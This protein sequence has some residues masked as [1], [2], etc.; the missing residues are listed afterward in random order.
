MMKYT[1]FGKLLRGN[2]FLANAGLVTRPLLP[3]LWESMP[4]PVLLITICGRQANKAQ[5]G[6]SRA[7]RLVRAP[8]PTV[9]KI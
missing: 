1:T 8:P 5:K 4:S 9:P 3:V 6:P 2:P 7:V